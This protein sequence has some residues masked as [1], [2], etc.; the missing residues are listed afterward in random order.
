VIDYFRFQHEKL[1]EVIIHLAATVRESWS[2][3]V[4]TATLFGYFHNLF[5]RHAAGGHLALDRILASPH[6]DCLCGPQSY[7]PAAR[8][9]GGTGHARGLIDPVRR[10]GKLWLD[11]MDQPTTIGG[12]PWDPSSITT[13]DDDVAVQIRNIL[14]PVTRGVGAWWYDFGMTG[15][16]PEAVRYGS[17]GWWD[18]P[19][20]QGDVKR[21]ATIVRE[22]LARPHA[23]SADVLVVHDPW[24]FIQTGSRRATTINQ[25]GDCCMKRP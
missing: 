22:R 18:H 20:L 7:D 19:R 8:Q 24:S 1:A 21:L 9:M 6:I 12:C 5:G 2:R 14:Q 16:T 4:V 15:G 3:P 13:L 25:L 10:A 11:E 17:M 23:R